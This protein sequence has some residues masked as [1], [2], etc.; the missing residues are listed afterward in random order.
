MIDTKGTNQLK[1]EL[2]TNTFN[3][4]NN[5]NNT[6]TG[7]PDSDYES[8]R[9]II[10]NPNSS[11]FEVD[12]GKSVN[13]FNKQMNLL[14]N[15]NREKCILLYLCPLKTKDAG[16]SAYTIPLNNKHCIIFGTNLDHP[17]SYAHEIA[18]TLG[19]DH[20]FLSRDSS[21]NLISLSDEK[22]KIDGEIAAFRIE[23]NRAK[24]DIDRQWNAYRA[25]N[26]AFFNANP[27][28]VNEYK[29]P[30]DE[31]KRKLEQQY[32]EYA[33][34][35]RDEKD[36]IDK[37][38]IK[39]LRSHTENIMDYWGDDAN[40]DGTVE[41]GITDKKSLNKFQWKIIQNEAKMYYH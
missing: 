10:T 17:Q 1:I 14:Y 30:Y 39:F 24:A 7:R 19:L 23:I 40:C 32:N 37:N 28:R 9:G 20:T 3:L 41:T 26:S 6:R 25:A 5:G 38:E 15:F 27:D 11:A 4:A 31:A 34:K 35:K 22:L 18:H 16:G 29:I 13:L 36:L 8:M 2:S 33:T 21:Y 12:S